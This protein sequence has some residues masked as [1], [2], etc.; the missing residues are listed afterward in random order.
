MTEILNINVVAGRVLKLTEFVFQKR[1]SLL[2]KYDETDLQ[3]GTFA[4]FYK[5]LCTFYFELKSDIKT[6]KELD[7]NLSDHFVRHNRFDLFVGIFSLFEDAIT[8]ILKSLLHDEY[9]LLKK[10]DIRR[11]LEDEEIS[12]LIKKHFPNDYKQL[13]DED[14]FVTFS[15]KIKTL[16]DQTIIT[17]KEKEFLEFT[18]CIRNTMH[19]NGVYHGRKRMFK[20][21]LK[22]GDKYSFVDG[23]DCLF[24]TTN[25]TIDCI[26]KI[27]NL[28]IS[29]LDQ[30]ELS[31]GIQ[32]NS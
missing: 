11:I 12:E 9:A 30:E 24:M 2:E 10:F 7:A 23:E 4:K 31:K 3:I 28:F 22:E 21:V 1:K 32:D 20:N 26:E 27:I 18:A 14:S 5:R 16:R 29:I 6:L 17:K 25:F 19:S 8:L 15:K 13:P